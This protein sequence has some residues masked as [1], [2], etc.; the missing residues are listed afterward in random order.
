MSNSRILCSPGGKRQVDDGGDHNSDCDYE[1]RRTYTSSRGDN[2]ITWM[3]V[4]LL[5]PALALAIYS[6]VK[7]GGNP[8][9]WAAQRKRKRALTT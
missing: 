5:N 1:N 8:G 4:F 3:R 7:S 9:C 2:H 6:R